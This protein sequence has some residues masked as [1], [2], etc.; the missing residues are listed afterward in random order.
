MRRHLIIPDTQIGPGVPLEHISWCANAIVDYRPDVIVMIGDWADMPSLSSYE[1]PGGM[2][3]EG[4]RIVEDIVVA[5][6]AAKV[7][8]APMEKEI[9]RLRRNH[10]KRWEPRRIFC[11]G[12]H[13]QRLD[14]VA[15]NDAKFEGVMSSDMIVLPGFETHP[16]L[17]IVE[18]D[19]V[20]Y[21]HYFANTLS[22]KPIG[23]S[24]DNRLNKIG[25][26][27]AQGHQQGFLYGCRQF[28]GNVTRHGIVAGSF[29]L[30]AEEYRGLQS[31]GEWRGVVV[32]NEVKDGA[33]DIMPLSMSYLQRKYG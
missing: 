11:K 26:S 29:Y 18:V 21:S 31:N 4:A 30:H 16:F 25:R 32:M 33:F 9:A 2:K 7:L 5:N 24:I 12:N 23:G 6:E 20:S 8:V 14:R 22:G 28:P 1:K 27:F 15:L 3:L 13:E 19:G 17:E 10:D